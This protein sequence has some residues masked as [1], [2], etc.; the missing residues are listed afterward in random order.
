VDKEMELSVSDLTYAREIGSRESGL[1]VV[2]ARRA[3][4]S[5][6]ASVVNAGVLRHPVS[7]ADVVAFVSRGR[8]R[9]LL[10]LRRDP[11]LT[12]VFRSGWDWAAV[13]GTAELVGPDDPLAGVE[14][15]ETPQLL[16]AIYS[17]AVG[18]DSDDWRAVDE[19]MA[20]ERHAAVLVSPLR[21][22]S[23]TP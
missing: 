20:V 23:G 14:R 3:D 2:I 13:E 16:R 19:Q 15:A 4:G 21:C 17:A 9:K 12:V 6:Y 7:G 22:Y 5:P 18:G 11:R 10:N 8:S 1:A